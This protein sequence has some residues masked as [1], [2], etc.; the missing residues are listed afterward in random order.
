MLIRIL[1]R[2]KITKALDYQLIDVLRAL[3][4]Y[5]RNCV[6]GRSWLVSD[7]DVW[8]YARGYI[9]PEAIQEFFP[10]AL[11]H[12]ATTRLAVAGERL[13]ERSALIHQ[14]ESGLFLRMIDSTAPLNLLPERR[15]IYGP[16]HFQATN[17]DIEIRC[18]EASPYEIVSFDEQLISCLQDIFNETELEE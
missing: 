4:T 1:A 18:D 6:I 5:S 3:S 11:T 9:G 7:L 15:L 2:C 13:M 8:S 12:Q 14:F 10:E 16:S 17:V